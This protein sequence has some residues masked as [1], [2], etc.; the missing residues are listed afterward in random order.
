MSQVPAAEG[1]LSQ[2]DPTTTDTPS[3]PNPPSEVSVYVSV[4]VCNV[5]VDVW[6]CPC[7]CVSHTWCIYGHIVQGRKPETIKL[8]L[9]SST[10]L[11]IKSNGIHVLLRRVPLLTQCV[12]VYMDFEYM[13]YNG[14]VHGRTALSPP[15]VSHV[16]LCCQPQTV[17]PLT[18]SV[19]SRGCGGGWAFQ[20][21]SLEC[22]F[23]AVLWTT[24]G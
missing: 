21:A 2:A 22:V 1:A 24:S 14:L 3:H 11:R 23:E 5:N 12:C 19:D 7:V 9:I 18:D 17:A 13:P 10:K 4:C 6:I 16:T 15:S 20:I 8:R